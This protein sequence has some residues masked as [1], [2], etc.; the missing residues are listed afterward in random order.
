M[1]RFTRSSLLR[2]VLSVSLIYR[3][4]TIPVATQHSAAFDKIARV[5]Q[6]YGKNLFLLSTDVSICLPLGCSSKQMRILRC[7]LLVQCPSRVG[8]FLLF[9]QGTFTIQILGQ[10]WRPWH[11]C[12]YDYSSLFL[13]EQSTQ[14]KSPSCNSSDEDITLLEKAFSAL[15][16]NPLLI[17]VQVKYIPFSIYTSTIVS[18]FLLNYS[19]RNVLVGSF[20]GDLL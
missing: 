7:S 9:A 16:V 8:S 18:T 13:H 15:H 19:L 14:G 2:F 1:D 20:V 3:T 12:I 10:T 6:Q 11:V 4:L 17:V 5:N